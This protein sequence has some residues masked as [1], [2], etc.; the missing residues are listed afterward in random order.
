[1]PPCP[2]MPPCRHDG[3]CRPVCAAR[4]QREAVGQEEQARRPREGTDCLAQEGKQPSQTSRRPRPP[5]YPILCMQSPGRKKTLDKMPDV[6]SRVRAKHLASTDK[7]ASMNALWYASARPRPHVFVVLSD[8]LASPQVRWRDQ[9][10]HG[11]HRDDQVR[12][13]GSGEERPA[14]VHPIHLSEDSR[15]VCSA[16]VPLAIFRRTILPGYGQRDL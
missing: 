12:R 11:N 3:T 8:M 2:I 1:M 4:T 10:G 6:G 7:I 15:A 13:R 14:Q 9:E 16:G 5:P